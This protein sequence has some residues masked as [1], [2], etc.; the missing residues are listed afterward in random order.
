[1]SIAPMLPKQ[2]EDYDEDFGDPWTPIVDALIYER[3]HEPMP[4]ELK[5]TVE[6]ATY[7]LLLLTLP[8][9]PRNEQQV[10][11]DMAEEGPPDI[12]LECTYTAGHDVVDIVVELGW[13]DTDY[14]MMIRA[15]GGEAG[16]LIR[17]RI[18]F[19]VRQ[20]ADYLEQLENEVYVW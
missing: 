1:M 7:A 2:W 17:E 15:A 11:L 3:L 20:N 16:N 12:H 19:F 10:L 4:Q 5:T 13:P 9:L 8:S 6:K 18:E 14:R